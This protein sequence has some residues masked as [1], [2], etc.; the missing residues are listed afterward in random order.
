M[1]D[2]ERE[3]LY[4]IFQQPLEIITAAYGGTIWEIL[5]AAGDL[6]GKISMN[7]D[8]T[9]PQVKLHH[10]LNWIPFSKP[11]EVLEASGELTWGLEKRGSEIKL[12]C[13]KEMVLNLILSSEICTENDWAYNWAGNMT[14]LRI[15]TDDRA[16]DKIR[17]PEKWDLVGLSIII[18]NQ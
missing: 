12:T 8:T 10:C 13:G 7:L 9:P 11:L 16:S 14:S 17:V 6:S 15:P 5:D 1:R 18:Q 2:C 4:P 3:K